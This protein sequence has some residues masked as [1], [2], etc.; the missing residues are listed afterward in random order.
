MER[1]GFHSHPTRST[2]RS[3]VSPYVSFLESNDPKGCPV[4]MDYPAGE[5]W[6]FYFTFEGRKT[7]GKILLRTDGKRIIPYSAHLP[8]KPKLRCE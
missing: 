3:N 1:S 4:Q 8:E 6:D 7:Y 5:T 2:F